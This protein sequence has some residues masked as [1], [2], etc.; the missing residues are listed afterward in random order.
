[1]SPVEVKRPT[2]SE[3]YATTVMSQIMRPT[4]ENI[5]GSQSIGRL[6]G[7][8]EKPA[9]AW[10]HQTHRKEKRKNRQGYDSN[11]SQDGASPGESLIRSQLG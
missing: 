11:T 9:S 5:R 6:G 1:M 7:M 2:S 10:L 4:T 3:Q 8:L